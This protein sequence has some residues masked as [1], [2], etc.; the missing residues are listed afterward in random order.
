MTTLA[1]IPDAERL[2]SD[3]LRMLPE[4]AVLVPSPVD[5]ARARIVGQPPRENGDVA[6][7]RVTKLDA[8]AT[9]QLRREERLVSYMLQFDCYAGSEGGHP[10]ATAI[11]LAVRAAIVDVPNRA[12]EGVVVTLATI[13]GDIRLPDTAYEPARERVVLTADIRMHTA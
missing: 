6:W 5:A 2:V 7:V 4:L 1:T 11:G 13:V 12:H 8:T 10:Q 9:G 3:Y